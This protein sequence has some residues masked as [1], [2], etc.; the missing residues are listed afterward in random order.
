MSWS[1]K[2][3]LVLNYNMALIFLRVGH[4]KIKIRKRKE[5]QING[6]SLLERL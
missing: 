1:F 4:G 2:T 6:R 3:R 5:D